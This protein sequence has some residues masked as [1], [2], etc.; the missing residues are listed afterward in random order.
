[1]DEGFCYYN[2]DLIK[3]VVRSIQNLELDGKDMY[4][5]KDQ[6]REALF[7]FFLIW[8]QAI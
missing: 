6:E 3:F 1:M 2:V 8:Q 4:L 5:M 7:V